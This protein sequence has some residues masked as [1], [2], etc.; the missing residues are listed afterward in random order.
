MF[1]NN[2]TAI[3][4]NCNNIEMRVYLQSLFPGKWTKIAN[5]DGLYLL[6]KSDTSKVMT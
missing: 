3:L 1:K 6:N 4:I 5:Y 2:N